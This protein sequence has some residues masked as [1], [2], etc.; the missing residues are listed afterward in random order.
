[1]FMKSNIKI[2]LAQE[3]EMDAIHDILIERC[4]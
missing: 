2:V 3:Y 1:M 4:K